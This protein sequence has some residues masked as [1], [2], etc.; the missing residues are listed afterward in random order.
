MHTAI[1]K[2]YQTFGGGGG[3]QVVFK[4][5]RLFRKTTQNIGKELKKRKELY[6]NY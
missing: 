6:A 1:K 5:N 4:K 3:T 2:L